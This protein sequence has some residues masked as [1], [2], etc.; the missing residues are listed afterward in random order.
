MPERRQP[1]QLI[2]LR[3]VPRQVLGHYTAAVIAIEKTYDETS[4]A[5]DV[6]LH[7]AGSDICPRGGTRS[8]I[9]FNQRRFC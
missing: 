9:T 3:P 8:A 6:L 2:A 4:D 7:V 1:A 5:M